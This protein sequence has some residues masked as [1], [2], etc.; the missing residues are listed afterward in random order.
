M[1]IR[2]LRTRLFGACIAGVLLASCG[3]SP[4]EGKPVPNQGAA[5][6]AKPAEGI[7]PPEMVA[8]VSSEAN[9]RVV[10]VHFSLKGAPVVNQALSVDIALVPHQ[11]LTT[12]H[13]HFEARD[14]LSIAT[15][16]DID[17]ISEPAAGK[18]LKHQ[19]V[20]LPVKEGVFMVMAVVDTG[21]NDGTVSRIYSIPIIVGPAAANP[22]TNPAPAP[23]AS[24]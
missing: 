23:A 14:G 5:K 3:D 24:P 18:L 21:T 6:P 17:I 15:G 10:S 13:V 12:V 20:L 19:M 2:S 9:A 1:T 22:A 11:V 8:A 16:N 7:V 4:D